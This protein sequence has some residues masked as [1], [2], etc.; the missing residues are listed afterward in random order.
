MPTFSLQDINEKISA[1]KAMFDEGGSMDTA[2]NNIS[3]VFKRSTTGWLAETEDM[4]IAD[5]K[6]FMD[7]FMMFSGQF[8]G[9]T[10][11]MIGNY[12]TL[13]AFHEKM[14]ND[15]RVKNYYDNDDEMRWV[16]RPGAFDKYAT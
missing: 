7:T 16:F 3:A 4:T 15:S 12:P 6:A 10:A 2:L 13:I 11:D 8:D 1:R 14:S 9:I 5:I